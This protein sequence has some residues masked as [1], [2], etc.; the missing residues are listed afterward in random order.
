MWTFAV[1]CYEIENEEEKTIPKSEE[2]KNRT[3]FLTENARQTWWNLR[4]CSF[5]KNE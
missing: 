2:A 5:L 4:I 1:V 3:E